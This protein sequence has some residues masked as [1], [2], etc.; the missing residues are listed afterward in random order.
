MINDHETIEVFIRVDVGNPTTAQW[1]WN[2]AE[3]KLL[4]SAVSQDKAKLKSLTKSL[5]NHGRLLFVVDQRSHHR[6]PAGRRR[7]SHRNPGRLPAGIWRCATSMISIRAR[8]KA[9]RKTPISST[10]PLTPC[11]KP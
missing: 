1:P 8:P 7:P 2:K 6:C 11:P 5:S 4:D 3:K 10:M 9:I